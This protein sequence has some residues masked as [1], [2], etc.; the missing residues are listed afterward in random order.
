MQVGGQGIAHLL[1]EGKT[2]VLLSFSPD[3]NLPCSPVNVVE[4]HRH[5][6]AG[7]EAEPGQQ[8]EDRVVPP[9]DLGA[10]ITA[11]QETFDLFCTEILG[12]GRQ[13]PVGHRGNASGEVR[14]DLSS[15]QQEAEEG[16][17]RRHHQLRSLWRHRA[18]MALDEARDV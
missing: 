7:P 11:A 5:H 10:L 9:S 12:D 1:G 2:I 16:P 6:F 4:F 14:H 17:Q 18:G 8:Q 13:P 3:R 15:L